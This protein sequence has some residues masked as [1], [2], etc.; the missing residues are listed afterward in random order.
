[1]EEEA[2]VH[3]GS[4]SRKN[5]GVSTGGVCFR[6]LHFPAA[7][8]QW[9][10]QAR[11]AGRPRGAESAGRGRR[12]TSCELEYQRPVLQQ[13]WS[14]KGRF[15]KDIPTHFV[16]SGQS[17]SLGPPLRSMSMHCSAG[18]LAFA[19]LNLRSGHPPPLNILYFLLTYI[20]K[21]SLD[22]GRR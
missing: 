3:D 11:V 22:G 17:G 6:G 10:S 5:N 19:E 15:L 4:E 7:S 13:R 8:C 2:V 9:A 20:N 18:R 14:S 1:M 12:R 21:R 16:Y